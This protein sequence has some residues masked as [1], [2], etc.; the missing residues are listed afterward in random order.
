MISPVHSVRGAR[1]VSFECLVN[2]TRHSQ[3]PVTVF[4]VCWH[5]SP[6]ATRVLDRDASPCRMPQQDHACLAARANAVEQRPR[7]LL[8]EARRR[9]S[10]GVRGF[11]GAIDPARGWT[12]LWERPT[13]W[14]TCVAVL[15][16][17]EQ[18][19][20]PLPS[21]KAYR[22]FA[23]RPLPRRP[24]LDQRAVRGCVTKYQDRWA[25]R[26]VTSRLFSDTTPTTDC[27]RPFATTEISR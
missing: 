22:R 11:V 13:I 5:L 19:A 9:R 20:R 1:Q 24:S 26:P 3:Q 12:G 10:K 6:H 21:D 4:P 17:V 23:T 14:L 15:V 27:S 25:P 8:H 7:P 18:A 16:A 2:Q